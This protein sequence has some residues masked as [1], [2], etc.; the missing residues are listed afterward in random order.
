MRPIT[1]LTALPCVGVADTFVGLGGNFALSWST[2]ATTITITMAVSLFN[3]LCA[4]VA[5]ALALEFLRSES[6][7]LSLQLDFP[8]LF[9]FSLVALVSLNSAG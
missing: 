2:T 1:N 8:A 9:L 6:P 4:T 5:R 3:M 7:A